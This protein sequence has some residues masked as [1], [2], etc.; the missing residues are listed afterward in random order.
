[1]WFTM[2]KLSLNVSK[3]NDMIFDN[4]C[5]TCDHNVIIDGINVERVHVTKFIGVIGD[6]QLKWKDQINFNCK[7]ISKSIS[8]LYKVKNILDNNSL[9]TLYCIVVIFRL[10]M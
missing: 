1:M 8:I 5:T 7:N 3:T 2:N 10:C 9:Y 6:D 4:K